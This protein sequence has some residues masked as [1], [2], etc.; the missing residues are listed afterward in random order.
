MDFYKFLE[1]VRVNECL[2]YCQGKIL[3]IGCGG[4]NLV[5]RYGNGVGVDIYPWPGV[6]IVCDTTNLPFGDSEFDRVFL[7]ACLNHILEKEKVL[8]EAY[9][10][11]KP[12]GMVIITMIGPKIGFLI[13]KFG[14]IFRWDRDQTER[15]MK[16]GESYGMT[17]KEVDELLE[18]VGF[19]EI[20][21]RKFELGINTIFFASKE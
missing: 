21:H 2:K 8:Q 9:R 3:D 4:N 17:E 5:R 13:H 20:S 1:T 6:D 18:K 11:L 15:G 19:K 12:G 16:K 7:I 10:V 14:K